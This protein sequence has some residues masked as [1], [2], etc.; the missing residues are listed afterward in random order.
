METWLKPESSVSIDGYSTIRADRN[1]HLS[2]KLI[3]GGLGIFMGNKWTTQM[4]IHEQICIPDYEILTVSFRPF[5]AS[6]VWAD[7]NSPDLCAWTKT[8]RDCRQDS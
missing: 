2:K 5:F 3:G 4:H 1:V 7:H 8:S 6:G